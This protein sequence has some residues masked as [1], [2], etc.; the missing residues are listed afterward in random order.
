[1]STTQSPAELSAALVAAVDA[2][3]AGVDGHTAVAAIEMA[4]SIMAQRAIANARAARTLNAIVHLGRA[5]GAPSDFDD[6]VAMLVALDL[7]T[8]DG[9]SGYKLTPQAILHAVP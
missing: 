9:A 3:I 6:A 1:M 7:I 2:V 8:P 4:A 5:T